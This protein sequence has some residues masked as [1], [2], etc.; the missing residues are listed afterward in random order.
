MLRDV[1]ITMLKWMRGIAALGAVALA[2]PAGAL[3]M[4]NLDF[5]EFA[6]G[7]KI[8]LTQGVVVT[9]ENFTMGHPDFAVA[10]DTAMPSSEDP[11]LVR[12]AG[13]V[14]GNLP[15]DTVLGKILIIQEDD[16][17]CDATNC[18]SP[19]DEGERLAGTVTFDFSAVGT[20]REFK[21]DLVDV[22]DGEITGGN[23]EFLLGATSVA[24]FGFD[25]FG[26][27]DFGDRTANRIDLGDVGGAFDTVV[28]TMGGSGGIDNAMAVVP[29]PGAAALLTLGLMGLG[30][31]RSR[32]RR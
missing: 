8:F 5:E 22:Q 14:L 7:D 12:G 6:N 3:T 32:R 20:F 10:F 31:T 13:W 9:T 30:L 19:D 21:F 4:I 25:E 24:S 27:A 16:S 23:I 29:E 1:E 15:A 18:T 26:D 11:D 28:V 17:S 2:A